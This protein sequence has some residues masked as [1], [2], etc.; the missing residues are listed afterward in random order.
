[1]SIVPNGG[2]SLSEGPKETGKSS[3]AYEQT[4][5]G[6]YEG[7]SSPDGHFLLRGKVI[8]GALRF[9]GGFYYFLYAFKNASRPDFGAFMFYALLGVGN[10]LLRGLIS[11]LGVMGV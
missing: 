2:A 8:L 7:P 10:I 6:G 11:A 9:A 5:Y 1:M 4:G 3:Y